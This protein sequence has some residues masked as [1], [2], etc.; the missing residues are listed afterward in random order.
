M[1]IGS[2]AL[3]THSHTIDN[4]AGERLTFV[5]INSDERGQYIECRNSVASGAGPPMQVHP[6]RKRA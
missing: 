1:A 2:S 5:A 4:G 6:F 3:S